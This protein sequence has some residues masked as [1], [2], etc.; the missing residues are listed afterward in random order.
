MI[1]D[2]KNLFNETNHVFDLCSGKIGEVI[3]DLFVC[4]SLFNNNELCYETAI[5][6]K[7]RFLN[8]L[9]NL[10]DSFE[11]FQAALNNNQI[12]RNS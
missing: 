6:D 10:L 3:T 1:S 2:S 8:S 5:K 9:K 12:Q 4:Q 11:E 7:R